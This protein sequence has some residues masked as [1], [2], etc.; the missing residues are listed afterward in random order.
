MSDGSRS[1]R[2]PPGQGWSKKGAGV[3]GVRSVLKVLVLEVL[4]V[5][6]LEVRRQLITDSGQR[7]AASG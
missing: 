2:R 1:V 6:V 4:G 3:P 7:L 5:L